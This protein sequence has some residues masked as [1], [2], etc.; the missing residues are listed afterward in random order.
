MLE[1]VPGEPLCVRYRKLGASDVGFDRHGVAKLLDWGLQVVPPGVSALSC[2]VQVFA[3]E[4]VRGVAADA[5]ADAFQLSAL[6]FHV[7]SGSRMFPGQTDYDILRMI[8]DGYRPDFA[9]AMPFVPAGFRD[10]LAKAAAH[11]LQDRY[12][13]AAELA[14]ELERW[15]EGFSADDTNALLSSLGLHDSR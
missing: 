5:R 7:L 6:L 11:Q 1:V 8:V 3:P 13:T 10:I 14:D 15:T 12:R 4:A 9:A 2:K